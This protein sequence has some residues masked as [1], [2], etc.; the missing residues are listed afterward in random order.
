MKTAL[1]LV[2][3][4]ISSAGAATRKSPDSADRAFE[5]AESLLEKGFYPAALS[6]LNGAYADL[7]PGDQRLA[8]FHE[9]TGAVKLREGKVREAR[10]A[11][12]AALKVA[13]RLGAGESAAKAYTGMGLCL[14]REKNDAY[15]LRFFKKALAGKLDEGTRMFV[16]DQIREIEGDPPLPAR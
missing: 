7:S 14:R 11:F 8:K 10:A 9:R 12:T 1:A 5:K 15:A 6:A 3:L 2:I 16:E 4:L 13:R